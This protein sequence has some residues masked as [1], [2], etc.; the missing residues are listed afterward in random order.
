MP[1]ITLVHIVG[2]QAAYSQLSF[3]GKIELDPCT[4]VQDAKTLFAKSL[5]A[6]CATQPNVSSSWFLI[7]IS[8]HFVLK[9]T[10][11][12]KY[13]SCIKYCSW[14]CFAQHQVFRDYSLLLCLNF[15][16]LVSL[17]VCSC[18]DML[19]LSFYTFFGVGGSVVI[20]DCSQHLDHMLLQF[21]DTRETEKVFL[22]LKKGSF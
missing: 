1:E 5:A 10:V 16:V 8:F 9:V 4:E 12:F 13:R 7:H 15:R 11:E 22:L 17:S 14:C 6:L 3:A 18:S 2:F 20:D 21:C 19:L